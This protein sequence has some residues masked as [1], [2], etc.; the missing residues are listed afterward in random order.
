MSP[1]LQ[2]LFARYRGM[3]W[4]QRSYALTVLLSLV[5]F[6]LAGINHWRARSYESMHR[7]IVATGAK[8]TR[9]VTVVDDSQEAYFQAI[10]GDFSG[11]A[12]TGMIGSGPDCTVDTPLLHD[13]RYFP[14]LSSLRL[15][16]VPLKSADFQQI[17]AIQNL[18]RLSLAARC[19]KCGD[20][21]KK[22]S[23]LLDLIHF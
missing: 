7:R 1:L 22:D 3:S 13:L 23:H 11:V 17:W 21:R 20:K 14:E 16:Q 4:G 2:S 5:V 19:R 18:N 6:G 8:S 10:L 12:L 9:S 15:P